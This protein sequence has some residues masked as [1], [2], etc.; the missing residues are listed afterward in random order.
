MQSEEQEREILRLTEI[1]NEAK[2]IKDN[3][4]DPSSSNQN[5]G[6]A[7]TDGRVRHSAVDDRQRDSAGNINEPGGP[8]AG[9]DGNNSRENDH[10]PGSLEALYQVYFKD[11]FDNLF[12]GQ[13]YSGNRNNP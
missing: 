6:P 1:V 11:F 10:Q 5:V 8:P 12:C 13:C 7:R 4:N 3:N 9:G 2:C